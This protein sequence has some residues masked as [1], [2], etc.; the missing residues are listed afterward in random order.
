MPR[1]A[2]FLT[3]IVTLFGIQSA[4]ADEKLDVV[5]TFS[6][7][8]DFV[9]NVGGDRVFDTH[10]YTPSPTDAKELA[11]ANVIFVNGLG[12]SKM[13]EDISGKDQWCL[14]RSQATNALN[15]SPSKRG[16]LGR[17]P[18]RSISEIHTGSP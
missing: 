5:A 2:I 9:K 10:V 11:D 17:H 15:G 13:R 6:I 14:V 12:L 16:C 1:Y 3:V 18:S 7:L 4:R 8:G